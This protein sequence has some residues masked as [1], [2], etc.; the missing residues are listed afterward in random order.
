MSEPVAVFDNQHDFLTALKT[1][2]TACWAVQS[3]VT[4]WFTAVSANKAMLIL[5]LAPA[6][7]YPG[8]LRQILQRRFLE[9]DALFACDLS[10]DEQQHLRLRRALS[11][12]AESVVAIDE[13]WR[14]AGLPPR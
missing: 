7:H 13:L 14:L 10:L 5:T 2:T 1:A 9:A 3:G 6:R 8:M 11:T 12:L 4:L